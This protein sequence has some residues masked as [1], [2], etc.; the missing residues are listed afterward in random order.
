MIA[1][2]IMKILLQSELI[3]IE[4]L[5]FS[6][7]YLNLPTGHF[8]IIALRGE[9]FHNCGHRCFGF[10]QILDLSIYILA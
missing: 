2:D 9:L 6:V 10:G 7:H 4:L 3:L 1:I 5:A 8:S